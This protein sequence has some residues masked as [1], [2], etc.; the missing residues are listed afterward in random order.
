MAL[1]DLKNYVL[2]CAECEHRPAVGQTIAQHFT[3]MEHTYR[4]DAKVVAGID[5]FIRGMATEDLRRWT[6]QVYN[7]LLER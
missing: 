3:H 7:V 5:G 4:N 2:G 6:S 1:N